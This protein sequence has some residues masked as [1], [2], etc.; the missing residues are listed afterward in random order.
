V[1]NRASIALV[2]KALDAAAP[3]GFAIALHIRSH[4]PLFLLQTFPVSWVEYYHSKG[5]V[6]KDPAMHWAFAN[7]GF[8]RWRDLMDDDPEQVMTAAKRHGLTYGF[9]TSLH[10]DK[11]RSLGGYA[12]D[13]RDF[14]DVEIDEIRA[15]FEELHTLTEGL[16]SHAEWD[17]E[18]LQKMSI[19]MTRGF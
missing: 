18:A 2:L 5:L 10:S 19:R 9:T 16:E 6:M 4:A 3:S 11:S 8:I 1:D 12:R 7:T 14:L 13:D 17:H 15:L